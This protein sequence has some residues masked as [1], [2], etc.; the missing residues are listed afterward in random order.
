VTVD[1][2]NALY[3]LLIRLRAETIY[4]CAST[5]EWIDK[6]LRLV[7]NEGDFKENPQ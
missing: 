3:D 1:E 6:V 2:L 5:D 4:N 7:E